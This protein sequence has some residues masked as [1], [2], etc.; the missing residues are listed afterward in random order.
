M[1]KSIGR[2]AHVIGYRLERD[3]EHLL[4]STSRLHRNA[5]V[6][7][8]E[9]HLLAPQR[10]AKTRPRRIMPFLKPLPYSSELLRREFMDIPQEGDRAKANH[11]P[12]R[13]DA[14]EGPPPMVIEKRWGEEAGLVPVA[15]LA[16]GEL[17]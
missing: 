2:L 11:I 16:G 13:V 17:G 14:T 4:P 9:R 1:R 10:E 6:G 3:G 15:Q 7:I 5:Q 12:K 8:D